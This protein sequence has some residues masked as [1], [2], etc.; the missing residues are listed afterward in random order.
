MFESGV[1]RLAFSSPSEGLQLEGPFGKFQ[2]GGCIIERPPHEWLRPRSFA[3][4][5]HEKNLDR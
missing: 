5:H 2:S 1:L 4:A 3:L